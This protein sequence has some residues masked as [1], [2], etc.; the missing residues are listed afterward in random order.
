MATPAWAEFRDF[1]KLFR[2]FEGSALGFVAHLCRGV[3]GAEPPED[4]PPPV[5]KCVEGTHETFPRLRELANAFLKDNSRKYGV[6]WVEFNTFSDEFWIDFQA[7][8]Q[9]YSRLRSQRHYRERYIPIFDEHVRKMRHWSLLFLNIVQ[10]REH[11][12]SPSAWTPPEGY[13]G[14]KTIDQDYGVPR[15]TLEGWA[16]HDK[17]LREQDPK[18]QEVY[19]PK[20]W[21]DGR[22]KK[23]KPRRKT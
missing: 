20:D 18:T 13:I 4:K 23:Y 21:V 14:S 11:D 9:S 3:S 6:D 15:T 22:Y 17:P 7:A 1:V 12:G 10:S 2:A 8:S 5:T 19:Y 16:K